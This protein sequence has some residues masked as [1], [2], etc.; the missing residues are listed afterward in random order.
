VEDGLE[1]PSLTTYGQGGRR[2]VEMAWGAI[3]EFNA[4]GMTA[5]VA[6]AEWPGEARKGLVLVDTGTN[7]NAHGATAGNVPVAI[8]GTNYRE[9][10]KAC[11]R[12]LLALASS[13]SRIEQES[14]VA[15][16][17]AWI[18]LNA[19]YYSNGSIYYTTTVGRRL[20]YSVTPPQRGPL[21]GKVFLL[22]YS[23]GPTLGVNAIINVSVDG[24]ANTPFARFTWEEYVGNSGANITHVP[25]IITVTVPVDG[26]AHTVMLTHA[27]SG[28]QFAHTDCCIVPSETP[29]QIL[30]LQSPLPVTK[31]AGWTA[32]QVA[33]WKVNA[34]TL[35][36]DVR[37]VV[38][39]FPNAYWVPTN[40]TPNGLWSTDGI[41]PNDRGMAQRGN[42]TLEAVKP[43]K[44]LLDALA[45][46][47]LPDGDFPV[48]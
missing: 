32:P 40:I 2:I 20:T 39:E 26:A 28:G 15:P 47:A 31:P 16:T 23:V 14:F 21:A 17:D 4:P 18:T 34:N 46:Q 38:A 3:N 12:T 30:V 37:S 13:A 25:T 1:A 19:G 8:S 11:Y 36:A 7:D 48:I 41:H 44:P 33:A 35:D 29:S 42:D 43:L 6:G 24:G 22:T 27:G 9:G 45:L 5:P 10:I